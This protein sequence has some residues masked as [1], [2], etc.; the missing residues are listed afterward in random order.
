M[1]DKKK[2]GLVLLRNFLFLYP[3]T[4]TALAKLFNVT[5][6]EGLLWSGY[7]YIGSSVLLAL[8]YF[9]VVKINRKYYLLFSLICL[10]LGVFLVWPMKQ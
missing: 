10:V 5:K 3:M 8:L 6:N 9:L 4:L 1:L 7:A 2:D